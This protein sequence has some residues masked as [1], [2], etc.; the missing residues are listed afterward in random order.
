MTNKEGHRR[1]GNVRRRE[2]GRWQARYPGPDGRMRSAPQAFARKSDAERYLTLIEAQMV[3]GEWADPERAKVTVGDYAERW[4]SERPNLRPRT[5]GLYRWTLRKHITPYLGRVSLGKLSATL[6][7]EWRSRLLADGVS[8]GMAAKAYRLL[9]VVLMTAL[10]EDEILHKNPCRIPG[11]DQEKAPERP[12]LTMQ[13]I[14][15]LAD[16]IPA[17]YRPMILLAAFASLRWGEVATLHRQNIDIEAR[18]I[19]VRQTFSEVRGVG[20]TV[21]PPKSRAGARTVSIPPSLVPVLVQHM[22]A[23]V[24]PGA[25][26]F[27]FTTETG[28]LIWRGTFNKLVG[29]RAAVE[30][31]GAPGLHFHDLRHTGNTLAARTGASL[32][33]LM[34][35]MGH[36]SSQAA[37]IYQH[38]SREADRAIAAALDN[39][40]KKIKK[41]ARG[42]KS[43]RRAEPRKRSD[44]G[45][46]GAQVSRS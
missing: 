7:R 10:K 6:V 17:R 37:M 21:G 29:W 19:T 20:L 42:P 1:F 27:V 15:D 11:A 25:D 13:Q 5:V 33:D 32:A 34:A 2:S 43:K 12:V 41:A 23:H 16:V 30:K 40:M 44:D 39:G 22:D 46:A 31:I 45:T 26:A 8:V 18:T 38:K 35:R 24:G 9:R 28:K 4:I 14:F 36:D 3:R